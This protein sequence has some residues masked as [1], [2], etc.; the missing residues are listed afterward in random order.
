M[1]AGIKLLIS[2]LDGTILETEDYHRLAYNALFRE[3]GLQKSWSKQDYVDRLQTMGGNKFREVFSWLGLPEK[4]FELTKKKL[5]QQKTRLYTELIT[6]GLSSGKLSLRSGIKPLFDEV[7]KAGIPIAIGTACVGWA[8]REVVSSGLGIDFLESLAVLCGGESTKKQKPNPDIYLLVAEKCG[9]SPCS[10]I[11]LED[12]RHGMLAAKNAGMTCLVSPSE[13]AK[14]HDFSEA[15]G[16]VASWGGPP[17]VTLKN[18]E[19][20]KNHGRL[21]NDFLMPDLS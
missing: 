18:L 7:Q 2:D 15:D 6:E 21:D 9:V 19:N 8:A 17:Q 20:M 1:S 13:F 12:T 11:V 10:C 3:L 4:E 16:Y 14:D 5:Y